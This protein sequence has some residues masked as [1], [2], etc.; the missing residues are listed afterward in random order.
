MIDPKERFTNR[1]DDY[2]RYRP[3]Y[4]V[5][6]Y[7][8]ISA[9][10]RL[11]EQS[12][13]A[14]VGS[15]TGIFS[16]GLLE[17]TR[18]S[19]FGVEPNRAMRAAAESALAGNGPLA[20]RFRSVAASAEATSL[21]PG[22]VDLVTAAQAFHWFDAV[23]A[24]V[25]FARI[26]KPGSMVALVWN[27]RSDSPMNRDYV[28]MLERFAPEYA[29]VR[30][31]DRVTEGKMATFFAPAAA[32]KAVFESEQTLDEAGFRGRLLSS[33]YAPPE[34]HPRHEPILIRLGEIFRTHARRGQVKVTYDTTVWIGPLGG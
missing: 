13:V 28:D 22:S 23:A 9:R 1:V 30:E 4:P 12:W 15:G 8:F 27:Q 25:E 6:L 26:L 14:D 19:V 2:V 17:S 34:N 24:R 21:P 3:G 20:A 11:D 32:T 10:A 29:H 33:S 7:E 16:R 18:A 5:A 31:K